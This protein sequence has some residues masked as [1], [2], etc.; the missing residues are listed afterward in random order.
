MSRDLK[1]EYEAMLDQ[2]IPDLWSRIEP[3]LAEKTGQG[4]PVQAMLHAEAV[5]EVQNR[6]QTADVQG[7][8][9]EAGIQSAGEQAV[10]RENSMQAEAKETGEQA[11]R[12]K[13]AQHEKKT[14]RRVRRSTIAVCGSLAAACLCLVIVLPAWRGSKKSNYE[15]NQT[16]ADTN[17]AGSPAD[18]TADNA[19][20]D[21]EA[22]QMESSIMNGMGSS[23]NGSDGSAGAYDD[24]AESAEAPAEES[25]SLKYGS[26]I[27]EDTA[28]QENGAEQERLENAENAAAEPEMTPGQ[29]EFGG[30]N[31][32]A[33]EPLPAYECDGEIV[34][35]WQTQEGFFYQMELL[36]GSMESASAET[37][38]L[39]WQKGNF[40]SDLLGAKEERLTVGER[41]TVLVE[42][43][44]VDGE[45]RY[46]LLGYEEADAE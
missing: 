37:T 32:S 16:A 42:P 17:M 45:T 39:L 43:E 14:H 23:D 4:R 20:A 24:F 8:R 30:E 7:I 22:P 10:F 26:E 3:R 2:E 13:T 12:G 19:A 38:I 33:P 21:M 25:E 11:I 18:T 15:M 46:V 28:V 41:Y 9:Q 31:D 29:T 1:N 5:Q 40:L 6:Q 27:A 36:G 34:D 44:V 35:A